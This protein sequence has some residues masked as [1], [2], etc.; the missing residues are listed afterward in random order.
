[1]RIFLVLLIAGFASGA[2]LA[3][4]LLGM[5]KQLLP[6]PKA[7]WIAFRNYDGRQ[8]VY[9]TH[10]VAYRCGLSQVRYSINSDTLDQQFDMPPCD[11]QRPNE[12]PGDY[13]PFL[14]LP[15]GT[16]QSLAVQAVYTDGEESEALRF[17]PCDIDDEGTCAR[18]I[19]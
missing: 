11:P 7:N 19:E 3:Q 17:S 1:M 4:G 8:L 12:I 5:E 10:L 2:A 6:M 18:L 13:L 16:A 15:L 14:A 9:F